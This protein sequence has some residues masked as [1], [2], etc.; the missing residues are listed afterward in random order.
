MRENPS[1]GLQ[2]N[3]GE[4]VD[5]E[6]GLVSRETFTS[7]DIY[8]QELTRIF[9]RTWICLGHNSEIP[10]PGDYMLR[11]LGSAPVIVARARDKSVQVMLNSC[12]H[13]GAK[14]CRADA[15]N[16]DNFVCPFHGW[17][18]K[19][20]GT[21]ITTGFDHH[22]PDDTNFFQLG[23]V[24]A[25]RVDCY[26]G[27][28]FA[29][30][31]E[32]VVKLV[33]YLGDIAWYLDAIFAR[34]PRGMEVLAPPHRWRS[35]SNWKIG[36]LN[37]IGDS[38]HS[39]T[40]HIGPST[41]D[42]S[43]TIKDGFRKLSSDSFHVITEEGHGCTLSYLSPG[44]PEENYLTHPDA[45]KTMY[46]NTLQP[47]QL[48]MLHHLRVVV[49]TVFP[50][51]SFI[52]SQ[53]GPGKKA[54]IVRLWQPFSG[55]EMEVLSW[56]FAECEATD[57]YK[58]EVLR[59]GFHNFGA[60]GVFEQDDMELWVSATEAS[61]NPIAR[62]YPFNFQTSL[63]YLDKPTE[64]HPWPGRVHRPSDTEVAQLAFMQRWDELMRSNR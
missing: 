29:C 22:F 18:Y 44:M 39:A 37:F 26:H 12:R 34:T 36:S 3:Q 55:T 53:V 47:H 52:E 51:F 2:G 45:L 13:R 4:W 10:D 1:N 24:H 33:D 64:D 11:R 61:D 28:I 32:E 25:P 15:G 5:I 35:K 57:G 40:T 49:G 8:R 23:L 31:D 27:L 59:N 17:S 56:V 46:E 38:Q 60:A 7:D 16:T 50:N 48:S 62:K 21:L 30:W 14:L 42:K 43:R 54:V 41:L 58:E 19:L 9:D 20:D 6:R 63:R